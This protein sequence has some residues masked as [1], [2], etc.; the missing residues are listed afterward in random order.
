MKDS[1]K[2]KDE[3]LVDIDETGNPIEKKNKVFLMKQM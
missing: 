2:E 1:N 3:N